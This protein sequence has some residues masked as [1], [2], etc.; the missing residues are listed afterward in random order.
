MA[1]QKKQQESLSASSEMYLVHLARLEEKGNPVPIRLLSEALEVSPVSANE[2]CRRLEQLGMLE[3]IPYRGA[4]LLEKGRDIADYVERRHRL[5]EVFLVDRLGLEPARADA[6]ACDLE[7]VTTDELEDRLDA[8]L[9]RPAHTPAGLPIPPAERQLRTLPLSALAVGTRAVVANI[10]GG[11]GIRE[12]LAQAELSAGAEIEIRARCN[13][14]TLL[15]VGDT[16]ITVMPEIEESVRVT[17]SEEGRY[18]AA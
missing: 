1:C 8:F 14:G 11:A 18:V 6:I 12:Y 13:H 16:F 4:R 17:V 9:G 15:M 10:G 2:M 5:W 3:Y 7:H